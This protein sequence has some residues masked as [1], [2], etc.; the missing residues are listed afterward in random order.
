[1]KSNVFARMLKGININPQLYLIN[2]DGSVQFWSEENRGW[3]V[4]GLTE[5]DIEEK[6]KSGEFKE[7]PFK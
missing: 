3:L 7:I 5:K 1:M 4:S 2:D 6:L